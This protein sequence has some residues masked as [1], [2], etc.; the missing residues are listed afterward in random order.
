MDKKNMDLNNFADKDGLFKVKDLQVN[1]DING[2]YT[3]RFHKTL[4]NQPSKI[5]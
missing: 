4:P 2:N 3:F 5:R 1:I